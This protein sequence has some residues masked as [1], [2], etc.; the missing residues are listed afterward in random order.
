MVAAPRLAEVPPSWRTREK[1]RARGISL[2]APKQR[3]KNMEKHQ[4]WEFLMDFFMGFHWFH[5]WKA[6]ELAS[7]HEDLAIKLEF[8]QPT[9]DGIENHEHVRFNQPGKH[10]DVSFNFFI[11]IGLLMI[12]DLIHYWITI[13]GLLDY[14]IIWITIRLLDWIK[15]FSSW[16]L[17]TKHCAEVHRWDFCG[18]LS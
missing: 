8:D 16:F 12:L 5:P 18:L 15:D 11:T 4:P 6:S 2:F 10:E 3:Q 14:W 17:F 7:E 13:I 1:K 9:F